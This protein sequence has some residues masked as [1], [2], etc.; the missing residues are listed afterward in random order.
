MRPEL[1]HRFC[2][3]CGEP[4]DHRWF[5]YP[6]HDPPHMCEGCAAEAIWWRGLECVLLAIAAFGADF[7]GYA[8]A[9]RP[10]G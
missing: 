2:G 7:I 1:N 10:Q 5:F 8:W 9:T 4:C 6:F 3:R